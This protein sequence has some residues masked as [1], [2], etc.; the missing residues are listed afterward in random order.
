M[1]TNRFNGESQ[2]G[3]LVDGDESSIGFIHF[4]VTSIY[5]YSRVLAK[6]EGEIVPSLYNP[7]FLFVCFSVKKLE[8]ITLKHTNAID[9]GGIHPLSRLFLDLENLANSIARKS[10]C[11]IWDSHFLKMRRS[12]FFIN[13]YMGLLWYKG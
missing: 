8:K 12:P 13:K 4:V 10:G 11:I 1:Q 5:F 7:F 2:S 3:F 6:W 9:N